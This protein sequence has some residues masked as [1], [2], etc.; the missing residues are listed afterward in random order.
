MR[1]NSLEPCFA[2]QL[3]CE[4]AS[5]A[6]TMRGASA[7]VEVWSDG[8]G[9]SLHIGNVPP[10][11]HLRT[12]AHAQQPVVIMNLCSWWTGYTDLIAQLGLE[13]NRF[14]AGRSDVLA[15]VTA[16]KKACLPRAAKDGGEGFAPARV[17][18]HCETGAFAAVLGCSR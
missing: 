3:G 7:T 16:L 2:V 17:L 5:Q 14:P 12:L 9:G 10:L 13:Q 18:L 4:R 11:A 8:L 1:T 6:R 15:I